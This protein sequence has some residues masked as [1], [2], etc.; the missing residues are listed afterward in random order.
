MEPDKSIT[1][2]PR[3]IVAT[4]PKQDM[5]LPRTI[6]MS[7][8]TMNHNQVLQ[9]KHPVLRTQLKLPPHMQTTAVT[10]GL[11]IMHRNNPPNQYSHSILISRPVI[12]TTAVVVRTITNS[13]FNLPR[14]IE[15][16]LTV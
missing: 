9:D 7:E 10:L 2:L 6:T 8:A 15:K 11:D 5:P 16:S 12:L 13:F 1:N 3:D 4:R 14:A